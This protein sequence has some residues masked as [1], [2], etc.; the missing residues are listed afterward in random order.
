MSVVA[1]ALVAA[2]LIFAIVRPRGLP[3]IVIALPAA[4]LTLLLGLVSVSA[5]AEQVTTLLP[6]VVFLAFILVLAHLADARGVFTWMASAMARSAHGSPHRLLVSVFAA[7]AVT[8][9]ILSLDA[10]VVLLTPA[11]VGAARALRMSA[12]PHSYASAHLSNSASTL[13]PVSN[14]TNLLAFSATGLTFVHFAALMALPWVAAVLIEFVVFWVFFRSDLK[15]TEAVPPPERV[16][17]PVGTLI[18]LG[19]TLVGF[20]VAGFFHVEPFWVAAAGALVLAVPSLRDGYT[21]P[22]RVLRAADLT[23]CGF[24][25]LL[26]IVVAGVT[27]GPIGR[28]LADILPT[29]PTF[30]G[31]LVT[32]AIAAVASNVVNNLPAT[33]MLLAAF[34]PSAPPGLLLAMVIGVNLGPN[35]TYVGSLAIMLW[36]RVAASNHEPADLRTFTVLGVITTPL[37]IVGSVAALWFSLGAQV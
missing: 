11:V 32:A 7:A 17:A 20:A 12:R 21:F 30:V 6:T 5:A 1:A 29:E 9:A 14:L 26:A 22:T 19:A 3:E 23:F 13:L 33:L 34:G 10:T 36:R 8:T 24:V 27:A 28:W 35:L 15:R 2:V 37:T 16:P 25:L 4:A 18:V 31:L